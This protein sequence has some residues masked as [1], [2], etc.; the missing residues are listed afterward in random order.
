MN[1]IDTI[2]KAALTCLFAC[3]S[4]FIFSQ[5]KA[6]KMWEYELRAGLNIGGSTPIP[7]PAE[8]RKINSYRAELN[9]V[10]A[11]RAT[12]W[13]EKNTK[14]GITSGLVVDYKGM[15]ESAEVKYWYTHLDVGEGEA[16]G[17]FSGT[18]SGENETKVK[19]GYFS[20]PLMATYRPFKTWKFH[21]GGYFSWMHTSGFKGT[22]SNGYIRSG[23]PTG[24][25]IEIKN[26]TFDFSEK[27]RSVDAGLILGADWRFRNR[28]AATGELTWGLV[29]VFPSDFKGICYNMY[30]I[31]FALGLAYRL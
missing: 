12:H 8:I 31:Y 29:P 4:L 23:G 19:N 17:S 2:R 30:N 15:K 7:L 26:A 5:E 16:K 9:P 27:L 3:F 18:F 13:F 24:E 28:M 21:G 25:R 20:I 10:L 14:W 22:A 1:N 6:A 11:L